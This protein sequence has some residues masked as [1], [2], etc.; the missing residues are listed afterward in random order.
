[1]L[2]LAAVAWLPAPGWA[3][4][5]VTFRMNWYWRGIQAPF[6]LALERGHFEQSGLD[7]ELLEGRG[8]ATTVKGGG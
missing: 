6:A 4:E 1:M 2:S 5:R 8:S 3:G 7:V